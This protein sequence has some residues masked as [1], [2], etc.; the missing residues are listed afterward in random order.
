MNIEVKIS[1]RRISY[2]IAMKFLDK[3]VEELKKNK[4]KELLWVLE[5]PTTYTAGIRSSDNEIID[6][7]IKIINTNR[8]GKITLH[9]PGQKVVYFALNL[10]NRK[11]DIR[12]LIGAI[13]KSIIEFLSIFKIKGEKDT[14]NIGIWV[15]KKKIAAIGIRISKW[16]AY[17]GFSINIDNNLN[18]Y[19]K[20]NPC[21]LSNKKITSVIKEKGRMVKNIEKKIIK[22]TIKNLDRF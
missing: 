14:K 12:K 22:I 13:E 3:R 15:N 5:H 7:K 16:I 21:G 19:L 4:G 17:H 11:K 8:G 9:N 20:I 1:K 10:N 18:E 2:E 6:K